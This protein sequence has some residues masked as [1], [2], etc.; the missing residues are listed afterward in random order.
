MKTRF[1]MIAGIS[2]M[3]LI[4]IGYVMWTEYGMV[5]NNAVADHLQKYSNLFDEDTTYET[6][7]INAIGLPFGVHPGNV[8]E[9]VDFILEKRIS[10][11][12]ENE[13]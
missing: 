7:G 11:D 3:L 9:C 1:L 2:S 13:D 12:L 5:C 10:M 4:P 6:Y 8:K